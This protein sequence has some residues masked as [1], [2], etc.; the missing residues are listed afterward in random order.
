[1]RFWPLDEYTPGRGQPSFDKQFVR[2][3]LESLD[4][5]KTPPAP[6]LPEEIISKTT[7]KYLEA[8]QKLTGRKLP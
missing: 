8:Y 5:D 2:D 6:G 4:W 1:S 3:Y 7:Q